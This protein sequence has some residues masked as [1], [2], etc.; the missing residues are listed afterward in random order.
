MDSTMDPEDGA[1]RRC[2]T[3]DLA[4]AGPE[5]LS[6]VRAWARGVLPDLGPEHLADVLIVAVE[7]VTNALD[8]GG[9]PRLIRLTR[10]RVPCLVT[11]EVEDSNNGALTMGV[12][13][14]GEAGHRGRGLVMIAK[15]AQDWGV[16]CDEPAVGKTVWS[17]VGCA[18]SP[19][20]PPAAKDVVDTARRPEVRTAWRPRDDHSAVRRPGGR[21][22][23]YRPGNRDGAR[24]TD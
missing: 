21:S 16:R 7:L 15:M 22:T 13:R 4:G 1:G 18:E 2:W 3:R 9:G 17:E 6:G 19:C 14:F 23:D 20:P 12:S 11:V 24:R 5:A 8:H 10:I